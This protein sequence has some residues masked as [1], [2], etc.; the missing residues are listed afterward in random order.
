[1]IRKA[2]VGMKEADSSL[3]SVLNDLFLPL[4]KRRVKELALSEEEEARYVSR[5]SR[6]VDSYGKDNS[7]A[8]GT[9][10]PCPCLMRF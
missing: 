1:M 9:F 2:T 7:V 10:L 3:L 5:L 6:E 4:S 8:I